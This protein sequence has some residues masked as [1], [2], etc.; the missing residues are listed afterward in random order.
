M[1]IKNS[2][3]QN[4]ALLIIV[5]GVLIFVELYIFFIFFCKIRNKAHTSGS[6]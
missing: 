3:F 6:E 1:N 4:K 2:L 5:A